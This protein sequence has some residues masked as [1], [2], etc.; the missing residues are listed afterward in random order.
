MTKKI[1]F[2]IL[3]IGS[4]SI[5]ILLFLKPINSSKKIINS[6]SPAPKLSSSTKPLKNL[7]NNLNQEIKNIYYGFPKLKKGE[8]SEWV[9]RF[10]NGTFGHQLAIYLGE[11]LI[12]NTPVQGIE[13][14]ATMADGSHPIVVVWFKKNSTDIVKIVVKGFKNDNSVICVSKEEVESIVPDF[15]SHIP[16]PTTPKKYLPNKQ[17]TTYGAYTTPT[18]KQIEVA[19]L[20]QGDTLTWLS[21]KV[22]FGMVKVI[23]QKNG[24]Q[25][26]EGYLYDFGKGGKTPKITQKEEDNCFYLP[27]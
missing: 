12:N 1:F 2:Y 27:F 20:S 10:D 22:P 9:T 3:A 14:D 13:L 23:D 8:W 26:V 11:K 5:A 16:T 25:E 19:K 15:I 18:G 21:S 24:K 4:L 6:K 17:H 7:S